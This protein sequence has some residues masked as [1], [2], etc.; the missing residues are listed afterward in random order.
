MLVTSRL[1]APVAPTEV[2]TAWGADVALITALMTA[3]TSRLEALVTTEVGGAGG[4]GAALRTALTIPAPSRWEAPSTAI[5]LDDWDVIAGFLTVVAPVTSRLK[6]PG[7]AVEVDARGV[8]VA[9]LTALTTPVTSRL[10]AP[11]TPTEVDAWGVVVA[12]FT[13]LTTPMASRFEATAT[14]EVG[15]RSAAPKGRDR[16]DSILFAAA[17]A[18]AAA[19]AATCRG[20]QLHRRRLTS[21]FEAFTPTPKTGDTLDITR[22][23]AAA[24]APSLRSWQG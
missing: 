21:Q 11:S 17:S 19:A 13:A 24:A 16:V 1:E 14:T 15:A 23:S 12:F 10:A 18:L 3:V 4:L 20:S 7:A 6:A 2:D 8:V 22:S 5:E 9:F